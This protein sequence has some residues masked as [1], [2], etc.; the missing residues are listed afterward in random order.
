MPPGVMKSALTSRT[1]EQTYLPGL[2]TIHVVS[3]VI[4]ADKRTIC[5]YA[6]TACSPAG[7]VFRFEVRFFEE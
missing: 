4:H 6:K 3:E 5:R 1:V 2:W 7:R